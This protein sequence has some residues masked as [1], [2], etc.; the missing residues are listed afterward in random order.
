LLICEI[1]LKYKKYIIK[2]NRT[3]KIH[4][5]KAYYLS[6]FWVISSLDF[7]V[8]NWADLLPFSQKGVQIKKQKNF[9]Q[10]KKKLFLK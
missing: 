8:Q 7:V 5:N 6:K 4:I 2:S 9:V 3:K 10:N 1:F